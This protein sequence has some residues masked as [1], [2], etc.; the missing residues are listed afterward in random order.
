MMGQTIRHTTTLIASALAAAFATP[1]LA[2]VTPQDVWDQW[3]GYLSAFGY[4]VEVEPVID[5]PD[6]RFPR[7]EMTMYIPSDPAS[8]IKGGTVVV[9]L[10]SVALL[11]QG[12]GTVAIEV[13]ASMP[14][15]VEGDGPGKEDFSALFSMMIEG[16]RTIASGVPGDIAYDFTAARIDLTLDEVEGRQGRMP[17]P[18]TIAVTMEGAA[19]MNRIASSGGTTKLEQSLTLGRLIYDFAL[20]DVDPGN[21]AEMTWKGE[22]SGLTM[23]SDGVVPPKVNPLAIDKALMSGYVVNTLMEFAAGKGAFGYTDPKTEMRIESASAGGKINIGMSAT[24]LDYNVLSEGIALSVAGSEIPFPIS[25]TAEAVGVG[26]KLPV[27][28]GANE[29]PFAANVAVTELT[30]PEPFWMMADPENGLPHDPV[31]V[32]LALSGK[33][34]L[35]VD[36]MNEAAMSRLDRVGGVPGELTA[37]NLEALTISGAGAEVK[38]AAVFDIDNTRKS[39]FNPEL[40]AFGGDADLTLRGVTTLLSKLGQLGLIPMQQAL[41]GSGMIQQLGKQGD[42]VDEYSADIKLTPEGAMTINGMAVP[43]Q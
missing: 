10:G 38:A 6:I 22:V 8:G 25:T 35:F 19:G 27:I 16:H 12:D 43:L 29:Q 30:I 13:P 32:E 15:T 21:P 24:G 33:T 20:K 4:T 28:A 9:G 14:I 23:A 18:G 36:I 5:G 17:I 40:P 34:R 3:A 26:I 31:T 11:S 7:F 2:D 1:S 37:L 42:G 39:A 41:I